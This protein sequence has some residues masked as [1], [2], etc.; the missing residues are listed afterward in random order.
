MQ[1]KH[2]LAVRVEHQ[3]DFYTE[4]DK[5]NRVVYH[6]DRW[7]YFAYKFYHDED[8]LITPYKVFHK[9]MRLYNPEFS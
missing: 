9:Y 1:F 5:H 4:Y 2:P 7:G 8:Y 3:Q 6:K